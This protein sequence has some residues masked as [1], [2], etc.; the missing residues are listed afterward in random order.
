MLCSDESAV[1][2]LT[3]LISQNAESLADDVAKLQSHYEEVNRDCDLI[4]VCD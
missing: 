4:E 2:D 3:L 1:T